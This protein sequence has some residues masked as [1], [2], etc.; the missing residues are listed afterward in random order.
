MI[1]MIIIFILMLVST[2]T[3]LTHRRKFQ[4]LASGKPELKV[5]PCLLSYKPKH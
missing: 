5:C 1:I 2:D 3:F 4:S